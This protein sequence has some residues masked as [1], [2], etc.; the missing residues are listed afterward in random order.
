[1]QLILQHRISPREGKIWI[2][3]KRRSRYLCSYQ[4][5]YSFHEDIDAALD[6]LMSDLQ[7]DWLWQLQG[8]ELRNLIQYLLQDLALA[9]VPFA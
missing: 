4:W 6:E 5:I 9:D 3:R 2:R 8:R 7:N 1:M